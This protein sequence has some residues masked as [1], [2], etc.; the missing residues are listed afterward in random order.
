MMQFLKLE[1]SGQEGNM[2]T[3]KYEQMETST[4]QIQSH[5]LSNSP[6]ASFQLEKAIEPGFSQATLTQ[7]TR[8]Y[9]SGCKQIHLL[10]A[11]LQADHQKAR[12]SS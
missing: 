5:P 1:L 2:Q 9:D 11:R 12:V 10:N 8:C 6:R 3:A 4:N 7:S